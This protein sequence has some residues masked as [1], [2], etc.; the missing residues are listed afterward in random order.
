ME[1]SLKLLLQRC[2]ESA[3]P[4]AI[5]EEELKKLEEAFAAMDQSDLSVR[6]LKRYLLGRI[7][8]KTE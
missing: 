6:S 1:E 7:T 5:T 2:K 3:K 8:L 4:V